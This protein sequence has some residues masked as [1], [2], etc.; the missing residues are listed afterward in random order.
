MP[1]TPP[2]SPI[3]AIGQSV[4][5]FF[6]RFNSSKKTTN[7]CS[8]EDNERPTSV[9]SEDS[10]VCSRSPTNKTLCEPSKTCEQKHTVSTN[11]LLIASPL[12]QL[13]KP[14]SST[15]LT[16]RYHERLHRVQK[17]TALTPIEGVPRKRFNADGTPSLIDMRTKLKTPPANNNLSNA[18]VLGIPTA[19][20]HV[21]LT[22]ASSCPVQQNRRNGSELS[23][24]CQTWPPRNYHFTYGKYR[25]ELWVG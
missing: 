20:G 16:K 19:N 23:H 5:R 11:P 1:T 9:S 4:S 24:L 13:Q 10:G 21:P 12:P 8:S 18:Q 17:P 15:L 2:L 3:A 7:R 25:C 14:T 22:V 6:R